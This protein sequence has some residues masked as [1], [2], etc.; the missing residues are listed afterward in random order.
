MKFQYKNGSYIGA[1]G[2]HSVDVEQVRN[3]IIVVNNEGLPF[4]GKPE[5]MADDVLFHILEKKSLKMGFL[6]VIYDSK[7]GTDKYGDYTTDV[8]FQA[9]CPFTY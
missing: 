9:V 1:E 8:V 3:A 7:G 6:P 4:R 2:L 5:A